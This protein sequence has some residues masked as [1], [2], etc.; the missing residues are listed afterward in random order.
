VKEVVGKVVG[1]A[2]L[3]AE[4]KA[5]KAEGKL[6]NGGRRAEERD[7]QGLRES[8][9]KAGTRRAGHVWVVA[10]SGFA[11][12]RR[13]KRERPS[14]AVAGLGRVSRPRAV[15]VVANPG[16]EGQAL[17]E[18]LVEASALTARPIR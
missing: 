17:N 3:H 1:D 16:V 10:C 8:P 5:D 13:E 18:G 14:D 12:A 2:K 7:P 11:R 15:V 6:Q 4:G 9:G